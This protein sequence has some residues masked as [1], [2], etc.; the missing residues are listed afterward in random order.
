MAKKGLANR[1][2]ISG[3]STTSGP[4]DPCLKGKQTHEEIRR[5]MVTCADCALDNVFSDIR[6]LLA[7]Q[8]QNGHKH[9]VTFS[10]VHKLLAT[11][12]QNGHKHL[13]TFSDVHKLLTTQTQN[14]HKNL[15]TFVDNHAYEES[16]HGPCNKLQVEQA[17]KALI[18]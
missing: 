6:K 9:L 10:G 15:I 1:L 4:C 12:T 16:I 11:Q 18:F 5:M 3:G 2:E 8:T 17:L 13:V 7:T 14:G